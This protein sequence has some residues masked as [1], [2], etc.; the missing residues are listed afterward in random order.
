MIWFVLGRMGAFLATLLVTMLLAY[1]LSSPLPGAHSVG[2]LRWFGGMMMGDF[3]T[4][5]GGSV[6]P[7]LAGALAVT[8]P[9]ALF[10]LLIALVVGT[11]LGYGVAVVPGPIGDRLVRALGGLGMAVPGFWLGMMLVVAFAGTLH[12][13]PPG[14]FVPW[15]QDVGA[16]LRSLV[17]P[18]VAL[19]VPTA[20]ALAL[21]ARDAFSRVVRAGWF[22]ATL[23]GGATRREALR[24]PALR[25]VAVTL[26][27]PLARHFATLI[28]G[29]VVIESVF[30]LPGLGRLLLD[31]I[32]ARDAVTVR[33]AI[34]TLVLLTAGTVF[35]IRLLALW[36]DPRIRAG[37]PR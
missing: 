8:V 37:A 19:A 16:A 4:G 30:Y 31:G 2:L 36:L 3:G 1:W 13:L 20:A 24:G 35:L 26:L 25:C 33:A 28:V 5:A 18:A 7:L 12:W 23:A 15:R 29:T 32:A 14:G 22:E 17:L 21:D 34:V 10:A 11:G 9:L 6:G 27:G